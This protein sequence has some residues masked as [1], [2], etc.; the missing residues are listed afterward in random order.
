MRPKYIII[1]IIALVG[2]AG[3]AYNWI[4][5]FRSQS[6]AP[7]PAVQAVRPPP[8]VQPQGQPSGDQKA[9]LP[10]NIQP[11]NAPQSQ[12]SQTPGQIVQLPDTVGR[13]PF[14]TPEE[15]EAIAR[16][17][18][19]EDLPPP[20]AVGDISLP[21]IKLNGVVQDNVTG[22]YRA[23]LNGRVYQR[24]DTVGIEQIAEVDSRSVV[25]E[26]RGNR[27]T[28]VLEN[29]KKEKGGAAGIKVK[30]IP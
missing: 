25:L 14:L 6:K 13:N 30:K 8:T 12:E 28:L 4:N 1:A 22:S 2:L 15:I 10:E 26:Y 18:L 17:E 27:R 16:G 3:G 5:Y 19:V 11:T 20:S 21:E 29:V 23:V 24:G 7:E 9:V